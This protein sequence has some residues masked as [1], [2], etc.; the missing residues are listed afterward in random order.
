MVVPARTLPLPATNS[1]FGVLAGPHGVPA[2]L[3][4]R[5]VVPAGAGARALR[6]M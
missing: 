2:L 5:A 3:L 1:A 6:A 4:D